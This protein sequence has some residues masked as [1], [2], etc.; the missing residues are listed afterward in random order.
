MCPPSSRSSSSGA[1]HSLDSSDANSHGHV[2][3][4]RKLGIVFAAQFEGREGVWCARVGGGLRCTLKKYV[5]S[6]MDTDAQASYM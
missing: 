4:L 5:R 2:S 6:D 1:Q 3:F